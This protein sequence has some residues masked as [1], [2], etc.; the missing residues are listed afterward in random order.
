MLSATGSLHAVIQGGQ[1]EEL[2]D[3]L[4]VQTLEKEVNTS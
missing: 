3:I 2:E 1:S 4:E